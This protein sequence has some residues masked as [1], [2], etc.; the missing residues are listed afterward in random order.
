MF[1]NALSS[2]VT[3]PPVILDALTELHRLINL[4][5]QKQWQH[6]SVVQ[7]EQG[8]AGRQ[9]MA[10]S[11]DCIKHLLELNLSVPY[12]ARLLVVSKRTVNRR[13]TEFNLP[14][15]GLYSPMTDEELDQCVSEIIS[16]Q[17]NSGYHMMKALLKVR[18]HR[19]Q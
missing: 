6:I 12:I 17:P 10:L 5:K 4:E 14:V 8:P 3:V 19:V 2:Q 11:P 13:M 15:K 9:W 1:L 16:R 7:F 18:G